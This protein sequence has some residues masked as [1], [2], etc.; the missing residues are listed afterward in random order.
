MVWGDK[1]EDRVRGHLSRYPILYSLIGGAAVV[2]FWRGVWH[3]NDWLSDYLGVPGYLDGP[4]SMVVGTVVLLATGLI[5]S[6]FIGERIIISGLKGEKKIVDKTI[7]ELESE[8]TTIK[9]IKSKVD[10]IEKETSELS[11]RKND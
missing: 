1:F 9:Q 10:K 8:E 6:S 5:V 3:S 11:Q 7:E 4:I 2:L